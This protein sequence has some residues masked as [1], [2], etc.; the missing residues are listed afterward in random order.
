[1]SVFPLKHGRQFKLPINFISYV[2]K[3]LFLSWFGFSFYSLWDLPDLLD[4]KK[5]FAS[6][7]GQIL[8]APT[9]THDYFDLD[10]LQVFSIITVFHH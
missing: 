7:M 5:M 10:F 6:F 4:K 2:N 1:M 9:Y 3:H 8:S